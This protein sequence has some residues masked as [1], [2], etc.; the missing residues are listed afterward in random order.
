MLEG[1][2]IKTPKY[3]KPQSI[4]TDDLGQLQSILGLQLTSPIPYSFRISSLDLT[5]KVKM[6]MAN[7]MAQ[8]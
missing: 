3:R 4:F 2:K 1:Q 7:M 8:R 5:H 6:A